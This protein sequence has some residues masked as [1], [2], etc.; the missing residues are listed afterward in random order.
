MSN[1]ATPPDDGGDIPK[2][3]MDVPLHPDLRQV[4]VTPSR[5]KK[6]L[7]AETPSN[8]PQ[9]WGKRSRSAY[10][11]P[12]F[13]AEMK[14]VFDRITATGKPVYYYFADA[15]AVGLS[16][17]SLYMRIHHSIKFLLEQMDNEENYYRNLYATSICVRKE[18]GVGY[19]IGPKSGPNAFGIVPRSGEELPAALAITRPP[20]KWRE[21]LD[22]FLKDNKTGDEF[23]VDGL[24][25]DRIM[26]RQLEEEFAPL[27][28]TYI[29]SFTYSK[30]FI[31]RTA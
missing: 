28:A 20:P 8:R 26:L 10:Y 29:W 4:I 5:M 30:I 1:I 22:A 23:C 7:A 24:T 13:G 11:K 17:T 15:R 18:V 27:H 25:L 31:V 14:E 9:G 6:M 12:F 2:N 3:R 19:C 16:S 21:R